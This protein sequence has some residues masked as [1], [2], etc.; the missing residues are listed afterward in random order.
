MAV[1]RWHPPMPWRQFQP[2]CSPFEGIE[3]LRHEME[4]L[5]ESFAGS[6]PPSGIRESMWTPRVDLLEYEHTCVLVADLPGMKEDDLTIAVQDNV[7]TLAGKRTFAY[8][9]HGHGRY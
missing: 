6:T 8:A 3:S 4:R 5:L 1:V 9:E 2:P 7:L